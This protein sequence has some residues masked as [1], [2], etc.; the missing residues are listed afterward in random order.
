M[1]AFSNQPSTFSDVQQDLTDYR[2]L[3]A[4]VNAP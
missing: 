2:L 1:N 4:M 3:F